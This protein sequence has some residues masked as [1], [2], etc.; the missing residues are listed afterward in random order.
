[1]IASSSL[2]N[3]S[4]APY[5]VATVGVGA[6]IALTLLNVGPIW[7]VLPLAGA[8]ILLLLVAR[9]STGTSQLLG[10]TVRVCEAVR[11][12]D[13]NERIILPT[14]RGRAKLVADR[15][16][17][18]IDIN[19]AFVREAALAMVAVSEGRYYRRIRPEGMRGAF[20]KSVTGINTAIDLMAAREQM[21]EAAVVELKRVASAATDGDLSPRIDGSRFSG[22]YLALSNSMNALLDNVSK[23]IA[24]A[25][26][27]LSAMAA[28][29][30]TARVSGQYA[31]AFGQL[32]DNINAV[33][34]NIAQ[35]MDQLRLT[36]R[37][38]KMATGEILAGAND[39]AE[40]T[41]R[42][43]AAIEETSATMEQLSSTV[44]ENARQA[45]EVAS[46]TQSA[47]L[48]ASEG[49]KVMLEATASMD[50]ITASSSKISNIIGMID[51]IAFQTN[52]LALNAS[53]EAAR[54]G[55]AG[56]G[57]AVVAV[58]VRRLAQSTA[59]ASAEVKQLVQQ[60]ARDVGEGSELVGKAASTLE[61]ILASVQESSRA[62]RGISEANRDQSAAINQVNL[63][64]RQMD[65]MTQHN[66]ALV[67]QTN[68]A[69]EQT[70]AQASDLDRIV[71][72]FRV[73]T[74]VEVEAPAPKR[75]HG[76]A[77]T[78]LR[79]AS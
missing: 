19:D 64:V 66:A 68:A 17:S 6:G 51:D 23:P 4:T 58:E 46:S 54:A 35:I 14:A 28:T 34:S 53:V 60:S 61:S 50:R 75:R 37:S 10:E 74:E 57:F 16:N 18:M 76:T 31:G 38:L 52:L 67:E 30:L 47:A 44:A 33:T 48:L 63:A 45:A 36:A 13:F 41:T 15:I 26:R 24:E 55:E 3:K 5:I 73:S 1:M 43:A 20:L 49:G 79:R 56:K 21:I 22:D 11:N 62:M 7:S 69:I 2:F 71:E 39:L 72:V 27:V 65:E 70:E 25:G 40:R 42:Q 78:S 12:G 59:E 9:T 32:Q 29:D 77:S 8:F